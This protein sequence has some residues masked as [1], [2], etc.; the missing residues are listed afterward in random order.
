MATNP[1]ADLEDMTRAQLM[2]EARR[3]RAGIRE[4]RDSSSCAV[5]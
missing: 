2:D 4:H 5:V 1:D 3:L